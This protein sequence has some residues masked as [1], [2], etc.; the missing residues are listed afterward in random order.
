ML[1]SSTVLPKSREEPA[2]RIRARWLRNPVDIVL[3]RKSRA[4]T[5]CPKSLVRQFLN[6]ECQTVW[7]IRKNGFA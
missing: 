1:C 2:F 6:C 3:L 4:K 5:I 7:A